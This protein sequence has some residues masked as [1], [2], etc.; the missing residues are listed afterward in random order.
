MGS[1]MVGHYSKRTL[2]FFY[3]T[4]IAANILCYFVVCDVI[5]DC[6]CRDICAVNIRSRH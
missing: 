3:L 2:D 1:P 5:I 4:F 6:S